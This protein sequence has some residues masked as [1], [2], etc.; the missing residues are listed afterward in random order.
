M[1]IAVID[2]DEAVRRALTRLMRAAGYQAEAY[3]SGAEFLRAVVEGSAPACIV[4]DLHMPE[5]N[6]FD[7]LIRVSRFSAHVPVVMITGAHDQQIALR[8]S[9]LGAY[10]CLSKAAGSTV[11]LDAIAAAIHNAA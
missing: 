5:L 4:L 1:R 6:G 8:A 10:A 7:M 11:L 3:G 2:D 9:E